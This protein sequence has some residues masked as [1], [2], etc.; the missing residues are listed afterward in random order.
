[1]KKFLIVFVVLA[2]VLSLAAIKIGVVLPMTGGIA[3]FGRMVWEGVEI[4]HELFPDVN[5]ETIELT[6]FDNR[7]DK[8][9]AANAVRRAIEV[10]KVNAILGEVAS[11]YSLSGGA[12]AEEKKTPMVTPSSTN[13]LVTSGKKYVSRVC[14]ID[15]FQG[16]AAA[17]LAH[18]NLGVRN[19]AIFMDVEQDYAVGLANFF[20]QT[21]QELGGHVFFE[22]YKSGDQDFTAQISDAML[23]GAEALFIPGYYQEIALIA[24]Q[25]RQLGFFGPLITGDGADAPETIS[26]GGDA[27]NGLYFTTHYH[28]DSPAV[29][30]NAKLFLT[31]YKEK[32][33]K[34]PAALSALGFDAYMVIRDA[35][36]RA[37]NT[38]REAIAQAIRTTSNFPGATG[39]INID[40]EGNAVKSVAIVKIEDGQFKYD[41]T[42]NPQ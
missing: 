22:Y 25:A 9:E 23:T 11:S 17:I 10:G 4:A 28:P 14:F 20:M 19:V 41:T 39:I 40:K 30:E 32:F 8:I 38:D 42:I 34:T 31:K 24:I 36:L 27:V 3:A 5:G 13:P 18:E 33:N 15:P 1:M 35:I 37:G 6:V 29:T 12:V 21:F 26:I 2:S 16:W 7:S